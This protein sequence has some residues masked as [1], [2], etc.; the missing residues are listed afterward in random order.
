MAT[1]KEKA[2]KVHIDDKKIKFHQMSG[3][4]YARNPLLNNK[5]SNQTNSQFFC[6]KLMICNIYQ[7]NKYNKSNKQKECNML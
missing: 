7:Q 3:G 5:K 6:Q 1:A 2:M 4:L